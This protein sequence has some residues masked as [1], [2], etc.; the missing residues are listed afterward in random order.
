MLRS[1]D[2]K[3]K[4]Y[5]YIILL[6]L[7][8]TIYNINYYSFFEDTFKI[9]KIKIFPDN[10]FF[11]EVNNLFNQNIFTVNK[12]NLK[13]LLIE[14][15]FL[16]SIEIKKIYPDTLEVLIIKSEPIAVINSKESF[17]YLGDNGR[18]FKHSKG[19]NSL[20]LLKGEIDITRAMNILNLL[21]E[22][23]YKLE[24]INEIIFF[25][26]KRIDIILK[27][28]KTLKFPT[29]INLKYINRTFKFLKAMNIEKQIVDFRIIGK[30]I[31]KDE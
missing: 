7:L 26:T 24:N 6:I 20:P 11:D 31:L 19:Y 5:F 4:I 27:D 2:K 12:T 1:K 13:Q 8:S 30:I 17:T 25:P 9:K 23:S 21:D 29:T 15:P 18:I 22:S 10:I 16:K 14:Y 28:G 3:I